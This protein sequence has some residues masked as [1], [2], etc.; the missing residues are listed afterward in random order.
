[1]D[2]VLSV[3][4]GC[5]GSINNELPGACNDDWPY[6]SAPTACNGPWPFLDA[7]ASRDSALTVPVTTGQTI[8]IRLSKFPAS[9]AGVFYFLL[10]FIVPP[11]FD[12]DE[13]V[14]ADDLAALE[15]CALGPE[16]RVT[17]DCQLKDLDHDGDVDQDDFGTFQRCYSGSGIQPEP[18]CAN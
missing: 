11:D 10:G 5:P 15:A 3:H 17:P 2:T 4:S 14:D 12:Q 1:M 6:G 9:A 18:T 16:V 13:D 7:G 8:W